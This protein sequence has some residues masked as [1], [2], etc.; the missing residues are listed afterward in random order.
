[1]DTLVLSINKHPNHKLRIALCSLYVGASRL[2]NIDKL[3]VLPFWKEDADYLTSLKVDPLLKLWYENY[4]RE[5]IWKTDG[6]LTF[7]SALRKKKL[8]RLPLVDDLR[9]WT[10]LEAKQFAKNLDIPLASSNKPAVLK[11]LKPFMMKEGN[12]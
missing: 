3:R 12:T 1:M 8:M 4:T 9:F 7:A 11:A 10:G 5:G 2:H 6:L